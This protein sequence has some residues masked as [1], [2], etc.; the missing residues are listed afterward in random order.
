MNM[1]HKIFILKMRRT[2]VLAEESCKFLG[3]LCKTYL[4]NSNQQSTCQDSY[5]S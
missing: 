3:Q 1:P 5:I 4:I 2:W